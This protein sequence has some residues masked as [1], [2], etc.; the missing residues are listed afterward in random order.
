MIAGKD[1]NSGPVV[2]VIIDIVQCAYTVF[3]THCKVIGTM[4]RSRVYKAGTGIGSHML[5]QNNGYLAIVKRMLH[6]QIF[7]HRTLAATEY[8][9][10]LNTGTGHYAGD[11]IF[12]DY[13]TL[14][15][16]LHHCISNLSIRTHGLVG[17]QCPRRSRPDHQGD[18]TL[19]G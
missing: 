17:R 1:F 7:E 4:I 16:N 9:K 8:R 3:L 11:Q 15:T 19:S 2:A 10:V 6:L 13:Q 14:I 5:T 12:S 18:I